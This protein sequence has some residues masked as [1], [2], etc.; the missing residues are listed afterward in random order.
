MKNDDIN[1]IYKSL[2]VDEID[3]IDLITSVWNSKIIILCSTLI[4]FFLSIVVTLNMPNIYTSKA[5]LT[6]TQLENGISS[7]LQKYSS[8]ASLA[9]VNI[10]SSSVSE[11]SSALKSLKSLKFF[12]E[13]V[14]P[15]IKLQDLM[16]AKYW[17][18]EISKL[19]YKEKLY[20][21]KNNKWIRDVKHPYKTIPSS[22][23]SHKVFIEKHLSIYEDPENDFVTISIEH[24][25]PNIAY[26]W[27]V[28][29]VDQIN[30]IYRAEYKKRTT[31]AINFLNIQLYKTDFAEV[32]EALSSIMQ[33]ET[34]KLMLIEANEDYVF[35]T[36]DPPF[37]PEIKTRPS[38]TIICII[39]SLIGAL[40]SIVFIICRYLYNL[41][42]V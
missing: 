42:K 32:K 35:R 21:V 1:N 27:L 2:E 5:L 20:D 23:E 12:E 24:I 18:Y 14:L 29:L 17:D 39:V 3:L 37:I 22:Q 26:D 36:I 41:N 31:D 33:E 25:S 10:P 34:E 8:I 13:S 15:N 11:A 4:A 30:S 16:A 6:P 40:L 9:G 38:R 7:S 28:L 19:S